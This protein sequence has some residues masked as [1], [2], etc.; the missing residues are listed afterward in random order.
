MPNPAEIFRANLQEAARLRELDLNG[1]AI[2]LGFRFEDRKWLERLWTKGLHRPDTRTKKKLNRLAAVLGIENPSDLW[3]EHFRPSPSSVMSDRDEWAELVGAIIW[4][5]QLFQ[6]AKIRQGSMVR[7]ALK[8]YGYK[9]S[10]FIADWIAH[11]RGIVRLG[12][13]DL[14]WLKEV[15]SE[16][17]N[18]LQY[19]FKQYG[20]IVK[21]VRE[22]A[23]SHPKWTQFEAQ[24]ALQANGDVDETLTEIVQTLQYRTLTP[25]EVCE[26]FI[27]VFLDGKDAPVTIEYGIIKAMVERLRTH[28]K[29]PTYVDERHN[30]SAIQAEAEVGRW[31]RETVEKAGAS[32]KP[33]TFTAFFERNILEPCG[34][35]KLDEAGAKASGMALDLRATIQFK[36]RRREPTPPQMI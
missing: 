31:W 6:Q 30:G 34:E 4:K 33:D 8:Q 26:Q 27:R 19:N 7:A 3:D 10:L 20:S 28:P 36:N 29:W 22:R 13:A 12:D 2:K 24:I 11:E 17:E 35:V 25:P 23:S 16:L 18:E 5:F 15:L 21:Y 14:E 9:E 32:V 1:M